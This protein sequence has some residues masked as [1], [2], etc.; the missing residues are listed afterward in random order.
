MVGASVAF[1]RSHFAGNSELT[2]N[3][4]ELL[5]LVPLFIM[6][7]A[8]TGTA[9]LLSVLNGTSAIAM[10]A[11]YGWKALRLLPTVVLFGVT[12]QPVGRP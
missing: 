7:A 1:I 11:D 5:W 3:R 2:D 6:F 8:L 9:E 4:S 12:I 10:I